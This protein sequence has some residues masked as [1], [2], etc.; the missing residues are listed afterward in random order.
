MKKD[1]IDLAIK[2]CQYKQGR[3][4]LMKYKNIFLVFVSFSLVS[5][6]TTGVT[7]LDRG[8]ASGSE[9]G[10]FQGL[11]DDT[12]EFLT[13]ARLNQYDKFMT[14]LNYGDV[15]I[16]AQSI[17]KKYTA[18]MYAIEAGGVRIVAELAQ[19]EGIDPNL[20]SRSGDTA[21]TLL[22]KVINI[23][24][25]ETNAARK[26]KKGEMLHI[27]KLSM[28]RALMS[29][30]N[31]DVS[32]RDSK[33]RTPLMLAVLAVKDLPRVRVEEP[34]AVAV[35]L[36][37]RGFDV[38]INAQDEDG[39]TAVMHAA[40]HGKKEYELKTL[41]LHP[42][43]DIQKRNGGDKTAFDLAVENHNHES[44][45]M[46]ENFVPIHVRMQNY[47][48][49]LD[50]AIHILAYIKQR[51]DIFDQSI[52]EPFKRDIRQSLDTS[53]NPQIDAIRSY[54]TKFQLL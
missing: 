35:L 17:L 46:L 24:N 5:C 43:V 48:F 50:E 16:N 12:R 42:E 28:M 19:Q 49:S 29:I 1:G 10:E 54:L 30:P 52:I 37:Q 20:T 41:L 38:D 2:A 45:K 44:A 40:T 33:G 15:D 27:I 36:R 31:I 23:G 32:V 11:G 6:K 4:Q 13:S 47:R 3:G 34:L 14:L 18:L 25:I 26:V 7:S 21:L 8:V 39:M 53:E 9:A 51:R 22:A